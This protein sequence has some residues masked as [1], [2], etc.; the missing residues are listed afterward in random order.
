MD[1][2]ADSIAAATRHLAAVEA[3]VV[4]LKQIASSVRPP[5]PLPNQFQTLSFF[6]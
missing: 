1:R 5:C 2:Y 6:L 3:D 4:R